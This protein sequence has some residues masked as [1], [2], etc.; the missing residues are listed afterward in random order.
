MSATCTIGVSGG[1]FMPAGEGRGLGPPDHG[2]R[3][4]RLLRVSRIL[5]SPALLPMLSQLFGVSHVAVSLTIT[6]A[7]A[8]VALA[9]P[10]IGLI[11]DR[12]GRKR[13]IVSSAILLALATLGAATADGLRPLLAWRFLQGI[14]TPRRLRRHRGLHP[15][16]VG[17]A[18]RRQRDRCLRDRHGHRR[19]HR[20][21]SLRDS[22]RR[23]G[24]GTCP[25]YLQG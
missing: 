1:R 14:C 7:T 17:R 21:A 4:R 19:L 18:G 13:V 10:L 23:V 16:G 22:S 11:A 9:A 24:T 20:G 3:P 25:S 15:G 6:V 12:F 5:R 8:G 2:R